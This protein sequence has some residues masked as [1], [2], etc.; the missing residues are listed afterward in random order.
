MAPDLIILQSQ[1]A[2]GLGLWLA[3][4]TQQLFFAETA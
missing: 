2:K 3:F 1:M 4:T